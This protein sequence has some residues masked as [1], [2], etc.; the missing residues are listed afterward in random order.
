MV[1]LLRLNVKNMLIIQML[2]TYSMHSQQ[3]EIKNDLIIKYKQ[4]HQEK[5]FDINK[6]NNKNKA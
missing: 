5:Y 4:N 3:E 1:K 2:R 6:I